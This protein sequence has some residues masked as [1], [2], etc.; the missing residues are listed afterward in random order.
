MW[1]GSCKCSQVARARPDTPTCRPGHR[2]G[3]PKESRTLLRTRTM[4]VPGTSMFISLFKHSK[5]Q[6]SP[7]TIPRV[8]PKCLSNKQC[9]ISTGECV[10]RS[11]PSPLF[12]FQLTDTAPLRLPMQYELNGEQTAA[13][14]TSSQPPSSRN[15][16]RS[17]RGRSAG[18]HNQ[19]IVESELTNSFAGIKYSSTLSVVKKDKILS[20]LTEREAYPTTQSAAAKGKAAQ[21]PFTSTT[22]DDVERCMPAA[23]PAGANSTFVTALK[24]R[25][26]EL[27]DVVENLLQKDADLRNERNPA[28]R[29]RKALALL[30]LVAEVF[31][32]VGGET[33][34]KGLEALS[35]DRRESV[36]DTVSFVANLPIAAD[37]PIANKVKEHR[38]ADLMKVARLRKADQ[39]KSNRSQASTAPTAASPDFEGAP[40]DRTIGDVYD[41]F[42]QVQDDVAEFRETSFNAQRAAF[43]QLDLI[44]SAMQDRMEDM[45]SS[46][47]SINSQLRNDRRSIA[48]S[49][50]APISQSEE[51]ETTG[52]RG[53]RT[54]QSIDSD[55][56]RSNRDEGP[57]KRSRRYRG[58][59][60]A[61]SQ[62]KQAHMSR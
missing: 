10:R 26:K 14:A 59:N 33:T 55:G 45:A 16:A 2:G 31:A 48:S 35:L 27:D 19:I 9:P 58:A 62:P 52:R 28:R 18:S 39:S 40:T 23:E 32:L 37:A 47:S 11:Q 6:E 8:G 49:S 21:V 44:L 38:L 5:S 20:V 54:A 50:P 36:L 12:G 29:P 15:P 53:K 22:D 7:R 41:A 43:E 30:D 3:C 17:R 13:M 34:A 46:I 4:A 56:R 57:S 25:E 1:R 24:A 42:L 60:Q 51:E 61:A